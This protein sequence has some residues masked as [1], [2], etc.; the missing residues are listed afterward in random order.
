MGRLELPKGVET[1]INKFLAL[2]GSRSPGVSCPVTSRLTRP[3]V[4]TDLG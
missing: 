2:D 1:G 3:S 4:E